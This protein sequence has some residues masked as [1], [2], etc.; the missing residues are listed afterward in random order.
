MIAFAYG[1][2]AHAEDVGAGLRF[3]HAH[4]ADPFARDRPWQNALPLS[5]IGVARE[6]V[7]EEHG[8]R[9]V[10]EAEARVRH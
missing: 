3:G 1:L 10:R 5:G 6:V 7:G 9:Q 4:T 2:A 8:M